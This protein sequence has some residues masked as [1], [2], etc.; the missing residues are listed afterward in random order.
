MVPSK[1]LIAGYSFEQICE[2]S[3]KIPHNR[4]ECKE[5]IRAIDR[6][7]K[8]FNA[9]EDE[10]IKCCFAESVGFAVAARD[11]FLLKEY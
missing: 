7:E 4:Q 2:L 6:I 9:M 3:T 8:A 1:F 10:R 5:M 11:G